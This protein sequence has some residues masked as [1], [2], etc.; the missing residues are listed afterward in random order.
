MTEF[1]SRQDEI[2]SAVR[3]HTL[4]IREALGEPRDSVETSRTRL[5]AAS[6]PS[7]KAFH[8]YSRALRMMNLRRENQP[9]ELRSPEPPPEREKRGRAVEGLLRAALDD[10]PSFAPAMTWLALALLH[11]R[12]PREERLP[13]AERAARLA[14]AEPPQTRYFITATAHHMRGSDDRRDL[15]RAIQDYEAVI[16]L[17]PDHY[18]SADTLRGIYSRLGRARDLTLLDLRVAD[19]VPR[20]TTLNFVVATRLLSEGNLEAARRYAVRAASSMSPSWRAANVDGA[21]TIRVFPA[22]SAWLEDDPRR[23]LQALDAVAA[24]AQDLPDAERR[25]VRMQLWQLYSAIGRLRQAAPIVSTIRPNDPNDV[26][27]FMADIAESAFLEDSGQVDR[28]RDLLATRARDP[29]PDD[30]PPYFGGRFLYLTTAGLLDLAERDRAWFKR[31]MKGVPQVRFVILNGDAQFELK[32]GR[33]APAI[34]LLREAA[35][36][37]E[38]RS[39]GGQTLFGASTLAAA[40]DEVGNGAEAVKVLE[41]A[42]GRRVSLSGSLTDAPVT[43]RY[44]MR[45]AAQLLGLYR[46]HGLEDKARD[47]E[48]RLLKLLELADPEYPLLREIR[49]GR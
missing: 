20:N 9:I 33:P 39:G 40:L 28:L 5:A 47:T 7:L 31:R 32:R 29:L 44:W 13:V 11:Q 38:A 16:A 34:S 17:Q 3:R 27:A 12:R 1:A 42:V 45:A 23:M 22:V 19:A 36:L 8:L 41:E 15:E 10:D 46:K 21:A 25:Q 43:I 24:A 26:Y 18:E 30:A 4:Q 37:P 6:L 35:S 48:A 14:D 49:A 2:V